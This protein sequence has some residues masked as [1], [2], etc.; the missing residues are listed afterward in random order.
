MI[1]ENHIFKDREDA[2]GELDFLCYHA[3]EALK[4][5]K[6]SKYKTLCH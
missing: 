6:L 3:F 2:S 1:K 4:K 5:P